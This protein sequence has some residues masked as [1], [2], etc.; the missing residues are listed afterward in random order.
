MLLDEI[1]NL[2]KT[3]L[4]V[5]KG[6]YYVIEGTH[7]YERDFSKVKVLVNPTNDNYTVY[8]DEDYKILDRS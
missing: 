7:V 4:G 5:P 2:F 1:Q 3:D 6:N 8:L